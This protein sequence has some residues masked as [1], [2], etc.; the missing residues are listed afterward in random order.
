MNSAPLFKIMLLPLLL[1]LTLTTCKS[2]VVGPGNDGPKGELPRDLT[3]VEKELIEADHSFSYKIFSR[4]VAYDQKEENIFIS[5]L[6]ISMALAMTLNGAEGQTF[7]DMRSTLELKGMD[8]EEINSSF[9]SL[10]ELLV[11]LDPS[12][13]LKIANSIWYREGFPVNSEF[14]QN[15]DEYFSA[16][17]Q[18]L[19]FSDPASVDVINNWVSENTEELIE[20]I[21]DEIPGD[22]VM[23]LINAL[24][25]KGEW[26]R[27]FDPDETTPA[28]FYLENGETVE[29]E[30]MNQQGRF[31]TY[32][33]EEVQMIELPYGDSLFTMT[34]L[35]PG[36]D[37]TPIDQFIEEQVTAENLDQWRSNLH[38][39]EYHQ[40]TVG[41]PR[42]EMEY[43]I[44]YND[45]LKAMGM[46]IAFTPG[47]A[48]FSGLIE[49]ESADLWIDEVKHKTF[50]RVDE[51]GTEAAAV[52]SVAIV[53][54]SLPPSMI[55]NRPFV[56]I[57]YERESGA[58]LF[59]GKIKNPPSLMD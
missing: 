31:A 2:D 16:Q 39:S 29:V 32:Q 59:M 5:P 8:L 17:I 44:T 30:M 14:Q 27:Q 50:I 7:E 38:V 37:E 48:D 49:S 33:N 34:I 13:Q 1:V 4:T 52:T 19:D 12:V 18:G 43:E 20:K 22:V 21:I 23:Y 36:N 56:F 41:L 9:K 26:L 54:T 6:S 28:D 47:M 55:V 45:V 35:M 53:E 25:F 11:S 10:M 58:N 57:I 3:V 42:F 51:E 46:E 15:M 24:Y 40:I